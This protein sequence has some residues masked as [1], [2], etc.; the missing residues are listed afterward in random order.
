MFGISLGLI[1]VIVIILLVFI[2][3]L[4]ILMVGRG[5]RSRKRYST[6][7]NKSDSH[8]QTAINLH[9][10]PELKH[11]E[12]MRRSKTQEGMYHTEHPYIHLD[13]SK[14]MSSFNRPAHPYIFDEAYKKPLLIKDTNAPGAGAYKGLA[15][16]AFMEQLDAQAGRHRF[17]ETFLPAAP[18]TDSMF[19]YTDDFEIKPGD[20]YLSS[21]MVKKDLGFSNRGS[22][23]WHD[24]VERR[25]VVIRPH[26]ET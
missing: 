10:I 9:N 1:F 20:P 26:K 18:I 7:S 17:S 23:L 14:D 13:P 8:L 25:P 12:D 22:G 4:L 21:P 16:E 3:L 6:W 19:R 15:Q 2:I 5:N 11:F 24:T